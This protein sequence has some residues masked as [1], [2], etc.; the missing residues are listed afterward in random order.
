MVP[1]T[2]IFP[3]GCIASDLPK[4]LVEPKPTRTLPVPANV[5]SRSPGAA[6]TTVIRKRQKEQSRI[7]V[8]PAA[9]DRCFIAWSPFSRTD[10]FL[11]SFDELA[12]SQFRADFP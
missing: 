11:F 3:S 12:E 4:S 7:A 10:F 5:V 6:D 9:S 8:S 2:T 1:A